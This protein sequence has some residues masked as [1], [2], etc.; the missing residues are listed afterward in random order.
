MQSY[1]WLSVSEDPAAFVEDWSKDKSSKMFV[2]TYKAR[3]SLASRPHSKKR[4]E[5]I[6]ACFMAWN[7]ITLHYVSGDT[8]ILSSEIHTVDVF[9][10]LTIGN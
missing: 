6:L 10:L 2:I 7:F 9:I 3:V 5:N 1:W 4:T 8:I